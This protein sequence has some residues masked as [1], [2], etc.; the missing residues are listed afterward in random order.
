VYRTQ[1]RLRRLSLPLDLDTHALKAPKSPSPFCEPRVRRLG[2][3]MRR[4]KAAPSHDIAIERT[5]H[6]T[7]RRGGFLTPVYAARTRQREFLILTRRAG[8]GDQH[9]SLYRALVATLR[10][11]G[12]LTD[13]YVYQSSPASVRDPQTGG[14][15]E[16]EELAARHPNHDLW[17]MAD[18][19]EFFEPY[20]AELPHWIAELS[21]WQERAIFSP[22]AVDVRLRAALEAQGVRVGTASTEGFSAA[23]S[24]VEAERPRMME[25]APRYPESL[26]RAPLK[27]IDRASPGEAAIEGALDE[28]DA[29]LGQEGMLLAGACAVYPETFWPLTLWLA[30]RLIPDAARR[31]SVLMRVTVLPWFRYGSIPDW[32][33]A[34]LVN[35]LGP[36]KAAVRAAVEEF[37]S[38]AERAGKAGKG[39]M[40]IARDDERG[41]AR[42][43]RDYV[44]FSFLLG[45]KVDED[46]AVKPPSWW[47]RVLFEGGRLMVGPLLWLYVAG[48]VVVGAGAWFAADFGLGFV[49]A[50]VDFTQ[51]NVPKPADIPKKRPR[52]FPENSFLRA[53]VEVADSKVGQRAGGDFEAGVVAAATLFEKGMVGDPTT[54]WAPAPGS[55]YDG[56]FVESVAGQTMVGIESR[57]GVIR[58]VSRAWPAGPFRAYYPSYLNPKDGLTYVWIPPGT[59]MMGCSPGDTECFDEEKPARQVSIAK[60]FWIGQTEVTQA[61]YQRVTGKNPSGFKGDRLPVETIT[62]D[63][64]KAYCVAIGG[65]MPTEAEWEYAARGG[66]T[67]ARYGTLGDIA[68][69]LENSGGKTHEVGQKQPNAFGLYDTLGNVWEWTADWYEEGKYRSLRGGSWGDYPRSMRVSV[70]LGSPPGLRLYGI[71]VRCVRE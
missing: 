34:R 5:L 63:E 58:R 27:W 67:S 4:R 24:A 49:P 45:R 20:S 32:M 16:L 43:L 54:T 46:L 33:R 56:G 60:G 10:E 68:W 44:M 21:R 65:R 7:V 38:N 55:A 2:L 13:L 35:R 42:P 29:W 53:I 40:A 19:A 61:A 36:H 18:P 25:Q 22:A 64:A 71:G 39:D 1:A 37:L 50:R 66:V 57:G 30:A 8:V 62:W 6:A 15:L 12:A 28:L 9:E 70:R 23:V 69:Y 59:F 47:L 3:E 41:N 11:Q 26:R 51:W 17:V 31:D 52:V 14:W 48:A